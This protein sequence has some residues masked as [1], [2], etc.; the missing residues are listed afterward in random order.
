[1]ISDNDDQNKLIDALFKLEGHQ[2]LTGD[3]ESI[4]ELLAMPDGGDIEFEI[5]PLSDWLFKAADLP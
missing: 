4:V 1:M 3:T 5:P 2:R